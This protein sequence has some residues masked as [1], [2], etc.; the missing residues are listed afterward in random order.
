MKF[1]KIVLGIVITLLVIFFIGSLFISKNFSIERS[2]V[3]K[4]P[5]SVAYNYVA[6]YTK[7]NIWSPWHEAEP[8]AKY[9]I[10]GNPGAP[11]YTYSWDDKDVGKGKFEIVK[12][13]PYKALYQKL[14]FIEPWASV[15]EDNMFFENTTEGT[16]VTWVFAGESQ[17]AKD[18]WMSLMYD[19]MVGKDYQKGLEKLKAELEK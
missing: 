8:N 9:S 3:I 17:S 15:N 7:F 18:K 6:D 14:S 11:G 10:S 19:K 5:D 1:L 2:I 16:K 4:V 13:E 12:A